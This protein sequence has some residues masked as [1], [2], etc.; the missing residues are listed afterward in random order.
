[1]A[2]INI[3]D[4]WW[5]DPRR[6]ALVRICGSEEYADG[7]AINL[8]RLAQNKEYLTSDGSFIPDTV[9]DDWQETSK[10]IEAKLIQKQGN[11]YYVKGSTE[12]LCWLNE[13]RSNA[14]KGG[15]SKS[16]E[17]TKHLKN[18][19][20]KT[21]AE[22][23]KLEPSSSFSISSSISHSKNKEFAAADASAPPKPKQSDPAKESRKEI[24]T[25]WLS[26]Y[27]SRK[28]VDYPH[29][30][31]AKLNSQIKR[32]HENLG[33]E[34]AKSFMS[35]FLSLNKPY[36]V[37]RGHSLALFESDL[38]AIASWASNPEKNVRDLNRFKKAK[39][40]IEN[41]NKSLS[42]ALEL[43]LRANQG[44]CD[45]VQQSLPSQTLGILPDEFDSTFERELLAGTNPN[46]VPSG[47]DDSIDL[48]EHF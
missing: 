20:S 29:H 37:E 19:R 9:M 43:R 18:A 46:N 34:K 23:S 16:K 48:P 41:D 3:E 14:A 24:L 32:I 35:A 6:K 36:Y 39:E 33:V 4:R 1:M 21:E 11:S 38:P 31:S 47:S 25:H 26:E 40:I 42:E 8:W 22:E 45:Q 15:A 30:P 13:R 10:L 12:S 7:L 5:T 28:L 27:R 44:H 17:K 2:R